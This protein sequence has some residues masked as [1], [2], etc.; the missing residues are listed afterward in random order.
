MN[1]VK[2]S[3]LNLFD[4]TGAA[5]GGTSLSGLQFPGSNTVAPTVENRSQILPLS[6][7]YV[8]PISN[9]T[10]AVCGG[11]VSVGQDWGDILLDF[12]AT[13]TGNLVVEIG[14]ISAVLPAASPPSFGLAEPLAKLTL[15]PSATSAPAN[16]DPYTLTTIASTTFSF[17]DATTRTTL[18]GN[19]EQVT[20]SANGGSANGFPVQVRVNTTEGLFYYVLIL[21]LNSLT[22]VRCNFRPVPSSG[23]FI[24]GVVKSET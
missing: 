8:F 15:S 16:L 10:P 9:A 11:V 20:L 5:V 17:F 4:A 1:R 24:N 7:G 18:Y 12:L 6:G 22:R 21:A 19:N 13:G 3:C 14:K 2:Q 23:S